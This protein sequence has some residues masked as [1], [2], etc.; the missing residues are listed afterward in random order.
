VPSVAAQHEPNF[1]GNLDCQL[2]SYRLVS[3]HD[4]ACWMLLRQLLSGLI[5]S[6]SDMVIYNGTDEGLP[7]LPYSAH[8][9][10]A[11]WTDAGDLIALDAANTGG[12][13]YQ[14]IQKPSAIPKRPAKTA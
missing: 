10:L 6:D 1:L 14:S 8:Q 13:V 3:N 7:L 9:I 5:D 11:P 2:T 4:I 12:F